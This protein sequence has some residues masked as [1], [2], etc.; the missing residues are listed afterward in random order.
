MK[1]KKGKIWLSAALSLAMVGTAVGGFTALKTLEAKA[2]GTPTL[3]EF[4]SWDGFKINGTSE[5]ATE[6]RTSITCVV[7]SWNR[8][9]L[10]AENVT[11][12]SQVEMELTSDKDVKLQ[13]TVFD[14]ASVATQYGTPITNETGALTANTKFTKSFKL[15]DLDS[16]GSA[17]SCCFAFY[18]DN[19]SSTPSGAKVIVDKFT[20]D[21]V[22]Y[23]PTVYTPENFVAAPDKAFK[24][25]GDWTGATNCT[26]TAGTLEAMPDTDDRYATA[27]DNGRATVTIPANSPTT[28]ADDGQVLSAWVEIPFYAA[29]ENGWP[30]DWMN[31]YVKLKAENITDVNFYFESI[32]NC[33]ECQNAAWKGW[34][35]YRFN[36]WSQYTPSVSEGFRMATEAMGS[37]IKAYTDYHAA[38]PT[39]IVMAFIVK[40]TAQAASVEIG[41]M[42]FA[43]ESPV[44]INDVGAPELAVGNFISWHT[45][46]FFAN[47][48]DDGK[49]NT[50][51]VDG[52]K[53]EGYKFSWDSTTQ[54]SPNAAAEISNFDA[55]KT[56]NLHIGFYTD[57]EIKLGIGSAGATGAGA[58]DADL[59]E[60][61]AYGVGYHNVEID[62]SGITA[63][64]F[65]LRFYFEGGL[66]MA[67]LTAAKSMVVDSIVFYEDLEIVFDE[68][69][70]N[71]LYTDIST[72]ETGISWKYDAASAGLYYQVN[73]PVNHWYSFVNRYLILDVSFSHDLKFGVY[74]DA[75]GG[76]TGGLIAHAEYQKGNYKLCLDAASVA[77]DN[78]LNKLYFYCDVANTSEISLEKTVTIKSISFSD[79]P[80]LS[81]PNAAVVTINY[82]ERTVSFDT[83]KYQVATTEDFATGTLLESG[84]AVTPGTK[85]YLREFRGEELSPVTQIDLAA[86]VLTEADAPK[87]TTV[88]E[89]AIRFSAQGYEYM[90]E[91]TDTAWKALGSWGNLEKGTEYTIKIRKAAT[92]SAFASEAVTVKVTTEGSKGGCKGSIAGGLGVGLLAC[93]LAAGAAVCFTKKRKN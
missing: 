35:G 22:S 29:L 71:G 70:S 10:Y 75:K 36:A 84:A 6:N 73:V 50:L 16:F 63:A 2:D 61:T 72:T 5:N 40:D 32:N 82:A 44:F 51:T 55:A 79:V 30:T 49:D 21:G 92:D 17:T 66:T 83:T 76:G 43:K 67:D 81:S 93:C 68:V 13:L 65:T 87:A 69:V 64:T 27:V 12:Q 18:F 77:G 89:D 19:D 85:I 58:W 34:H 57:S 80:L 42:T 25:Y 1:T 53:Y 4:V 31:F 52:D 78:E 11:S 88:T 48:G 8:S 28:T 86:T 41:G 54:D 46:F 59:S 47:P 38:M 24:E 90:L 33:D 45:N 62:V 39:K 37:R 74:F 15:G 7:A 60:A 26:V 56:P 3:T 23:T 14:H 20:V 91:G 9:L